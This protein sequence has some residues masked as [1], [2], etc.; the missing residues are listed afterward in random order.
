MNP[1]SAMILW[2][3]FAIVFLFVEAMTPQLLSIWFSVGA[4]AALIAAALSAPFWLQILIFLFV[5][6]GVVFAMRPLSQKFRIRSEEHMN[7]NRIIGRHGIVVQTIDP[8]K[9]EGQI[10]VD[11]AIWSAKCEGETPI[12]EGVR[13]KVQRIE[14]VKAVVRVSRIQ[15]EEEKT[16]E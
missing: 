9:N 6:V 16:G 15:P 14:G 7:A 10:R 11:G 12:V 3:S 1:T 8:V 4:L 13:V 5:S 2:G